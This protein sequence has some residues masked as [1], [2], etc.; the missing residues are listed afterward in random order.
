MQMQSEIKSTENV[1][2]TSLLVSKL[3]S[4]QEPLES[5]RKLGFIMFDFVIHTWGQA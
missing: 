4:Q 5:L 1:L 2:R 3:V